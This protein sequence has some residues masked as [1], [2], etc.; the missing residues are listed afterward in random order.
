[1]GTYGIL[2][3]MNF[4]DSEGGRNRLGDAKIEAT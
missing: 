4:I 2:S 3:L 1:M